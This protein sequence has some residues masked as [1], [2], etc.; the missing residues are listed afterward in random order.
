MANQ[1]LEPVELV[2][3]PGAGARVAAGHAHGRDPQA[4]DGGLDVAG[5]RVRRV[6]RQRVA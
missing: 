3:K 6:A 1:A 5:L 4:R 2:S